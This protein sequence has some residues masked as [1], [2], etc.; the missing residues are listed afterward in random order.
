MRPRQRAQVV[1]RP[2]LFW[3]PRQE[4]GVAGLSRDELNGKVGLATRFVADRQRYAVAL[5][6]GDDDKPL[7]V[8]PSNLEPADAPGEDLRPK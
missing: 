1:S 8:K 7:S 3:L 5:D 4:I 2:K 6:G